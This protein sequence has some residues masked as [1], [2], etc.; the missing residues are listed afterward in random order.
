M[1]NPD[2][3]RVGFVASGDADAVHDAATGGNNTKLYVK[4]SVT[5]NAV[6]P[7]ARYATVYSGCNNVYF[8]KHNA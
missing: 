8:L 1:M 4:V 6:G 3:P 7:A 5:G 2:K